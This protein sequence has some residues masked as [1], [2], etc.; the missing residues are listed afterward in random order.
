MLIIGD[1]YTLAY[2]KLFRTRFSVKKKNQR[3]P[4]ST[5]LHFLFLHR[6]LSYS[7]PLILI[8]ELKAR[9][10]KSQ[11]FICSLVD[12]WQ[13][14]H[15]NFKAGPNSDSSKLRITQ[16]HHTRRCFLNPGRCCGFW[17]NNFKEV[18]LRHKNP[19]PGLAC[20]R[21]WLPCDGKF[22]EDKFRKK[23]WW[24]KILIRLHAR[25]SA[26]SRTSCSLLEP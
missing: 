25:R 2:S 8:Y 3:C 20:T 21:K 11:V 14:T 1:V 6:P 26:N 7:K 23:D 5:P 18:L 15:Q 22:E 12:T 17:N 16:T 9:A 10:A 24:D 13:A 19:R 4:S